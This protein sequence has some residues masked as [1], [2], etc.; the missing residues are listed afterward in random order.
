VTFGFLTFLPFL[1]INKGAGVEVVGLAVALVFG[2]GALGKFLCG[3]L[4]ERFGIVRTMVLTELATG[5]GLL[6]LLFLPL[7][8]ALAL[9]PV[10][11]VALNGTSS[12]LYAT[13]ADFIAPERHTR[14]FAFFYT[15][16]MGA[17]AVSPLIFGLVSDTFGVSTSMVILG[18]GIFLTIPLC[19]AVPTVN[20]SVEQATEQLSE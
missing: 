4:A 13:V 16:G 18:F 11:G 12:V 3:V 17:G 19:L 1:L 20:G 10:I 14:G 7:A 8:G 15:V 6:A 5:A 2:G 9:L